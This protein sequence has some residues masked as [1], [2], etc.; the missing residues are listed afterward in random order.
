MVTP[1]SPAE[2][3][4][5][6]IGM[7]DEAPG[8]D[9]RRKSDLT[10]LSAVTLA[11]RFNIWLLVGIAPESFRHGVTVLIPKSRGSDKPEV[12][13]P[14]TM[15]PI[16]CRLYHRILA[17]RIEAAY[18]ISERQK[19]F[20]KGDG[21]A[22]NT[23]ILRYVLS[24]RQT[25]CQS[26]A[27]A[28]L[29]VSNA[30]DS[31]SH[32]SI[33]LAAASAGIP[34]PLVEYIRSLYAGSS[35]R[36]RVSGEL[37]EEVNVT[38]GVRQGDPLSPV[39]F[40]SV[41]DIAL[42]H[43]DSKIG[44]PVGDQMLSCLAFADDLVLLA[45]TPRG[46]QHQF[47]VIERALGLCGLT[48]NARKC[49]T[50]RIDVLG[51]EKTWA[52]NPSDFM[53]SRDGSM[54]R[55]MDVAD[56]YKYLGN[57]VCAGKAPDTTLNTL[58]EGVDQLSRAPLKPQ[59]RMFFLRC[60][61]LP[62]LLHKAVL[63]RMSR[64]TLDFLDKITRA[65]IRSWVNL[66]K[67]TPMAFFH[68]DQRDGGL[69]MP[70]LKLSVPLLRIRRITRMVTSEDPVVRGITQLPSF[71]RDVRFW[72]K[73]LSMF[74]CPIRDGAG[75]Q[76]AMAHGLHTSVDGRGLSDC[77]DTGFV[78]QWMVSHAELIS[79][80]QRLGI[81]GRAL[82]WFTSYLTDREQYTQ[83]GLSKSSSE[84]MRCGVPQGSVLGPILFTIYT[85]S[86]GSLFRSHNMNYQLYSDDS[87][88]YVIF[89]PTEQ[90]AAVQ[91][92]E[93]CLASVRKWMCH[94]S[95]KLNDKKTE[96]LLISTKQLATK[97]N[98]HTLLIGEHEVT[99]ATV[100]RNIGVIMDTHASMEAHVNNVSRTAYYHLYNIGR[101]RC[102]LSQSAAEQ[103]VH[104]FITSKL[105]Y[106]NALLCGLTSLLTKKLQRI[107]NAAA[108]SI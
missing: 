89:K 86:L 83:I 52:C 74:G 10:N 46:L 42:R 50:L 44:V 96:M 79:T 108:N 32:D 19:A 43:I 93:T 53:S 62:S 12:F 69:A 25:R 60:N 80:L 56:G 98:C 102:Y 57:L 55:A 26:T 15:G 88:T 39:L 6:L 101:I 84:P 58:R 49:A 23:L 20:R 91:R 48:L 75:I 104:A 27:L 24:D 95:L 54:I 70:M 5:H 65:A 34:E 18:G 66:P 99:P 31:V 28:F 21:I 51:K 33:F 81:T 68:A 11:C 106:C 9:L 38:R 78:N 77:R 90:A 40:N 4:K 30:F 82:Q 64:R 92:M 35:T 67:D 73:P 37:S 87:Q 107:Q 63:G 41:I 1:I 7:K 105:D 59:Q 97:L 36:L 14:I 100:V 17:A 61:L 3:A 76:R 16:M 103:L 71:Q 72:S 13:R 47:T 22:D 2:V 94:K 85:T 8:P 45:K 29:D